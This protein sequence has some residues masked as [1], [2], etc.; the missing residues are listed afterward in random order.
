M[1]EKIKFALQGFY[2]G[3]NCAQAVIMAYANE[4]GM[5]T[6]L[7]MNMASG[8]GGGM[9]KLQKTCGAASGSYMLIGLRNTE[10]IDDDMQRAAATPKMIQNFNKQFVRING[11]DQCSEL[12]K[13][14]LKTEEGKKRF[15]EKNLKDK[16]CSKCVSSAIE[17]L[18]EMFN[19]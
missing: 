9:G 5:D 8:F 18:E 17:L 2:E 1:E 14:D 11:S 10:K 15:Q 7:A 6:Q 13:L 19:H 12:L 3:K 4:Y 16:V